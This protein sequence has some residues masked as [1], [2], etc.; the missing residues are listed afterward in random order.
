MTTLEDTARLVTYFQAKWPHS[1]LAKL[2]K[3][4]LT[5]TVKAWRD[6]FADLSQEAVWAAARHLSS[7][8][9]AFPPSPG[10]VRQK[11]FD[12]LDADKGIPSAVEAW[13]EV[14]K[15]FTAHRSQMKWSH[16]HVEAAVEAMGG[17]RNMGQEPVDMIAS[18]RARFIQVYEVIAKREREQERMLPEVRE[19]IKAL[20]GKMSGGLLEEGA[21]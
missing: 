15:M 19:A 21:E 1:E 16:P 4:K 17:F 11:A 18:T 8:D 14:Q 5:A 9:R 6:D 20:A 2:P 13:G 12:L 10:M 7:G 3:R